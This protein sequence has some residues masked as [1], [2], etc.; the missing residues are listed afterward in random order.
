VIKNKTTDRGSAEEIGRGGP[1]RPIPEECEDAYGEGVEFGPG[2]II[3]DVISRIN[4][5][6]ES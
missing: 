1:L 6:E 2:E 4:E 5:S 3:P